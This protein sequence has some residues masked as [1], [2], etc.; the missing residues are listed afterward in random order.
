MFQTLIN[1]MGLTWEF[2]Q[3]S[4][5][6]VF[7]D[8]TIMLTNGKITTKLYAKPMA[9]HLYIPPF[10]CHAPRVTTGLIHGHFYHVIMLC[11]YQHDIKRELSKFF[12]RLLDRGYT[13]N[14]LL[15][16]FPL[17]RTK[18]HLSLSTM[19]PPTNKPVSYHTTTA[20]QQRK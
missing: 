12:Q 9:L 5:E 7:M 2:S 15:P 11:T 8:L 3:R 13:I 1:G 14:F 19:P 10:S 20:K 17:S 16:I 18:S 6:A 4:N